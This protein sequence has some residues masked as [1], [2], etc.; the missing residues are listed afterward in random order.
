MLAGSKHWP[1]D[2][3]VK[4]WKWFM[5]HIKNVFNQ[6]SNETLSVWSSFFEVR[7]VLF[8]ATVNGNG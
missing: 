7:S 2:S 3:Q 1:T 6:K 4:I 8:T 5:P